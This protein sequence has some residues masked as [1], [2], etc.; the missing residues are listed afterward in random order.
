MQKNNNS[1]IHHQISSYEEKQKAKLVE[2]SQSNKSYKNILAYLEA[3]IKHLQMSTFNYKIHCF[4]DDGVYQLNRAIEAV[5]GSVNFK[6]DESPSGGDVM[7]TIDIQLATGERIKT[8]YG[9]I[10]LPEAGEDA[11]IDIL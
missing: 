1:R 5:Y 10:A 8:L 2:L 6:K 9:Q 4:K 3:E 11:H 7:Q